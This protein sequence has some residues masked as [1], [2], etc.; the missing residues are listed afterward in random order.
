MHSP[1]LLLATAGLA[2]SRAGDYARSQR[3]RR[4][5]ANAVLQHDIKHKLD[6]ECEAIATRIL[7]DAFPES[8]ILGE[9]TSTEDGAPPPPAKGVE[10]IIDPIDGTVN[11]F[12]GLP[13]WNCSIAARVDGVV[14]AGV[15]YAPE[16]GYRFEATVDGP[17]LLNGLPIHTSATD[18]LAACTVHTGADRNEDPLKANRFFNALSE[19]CQRPR[20]MGTAA[21]DVCAVAAG[22]ADAYFEH[23][24]YIWDIAAAGLIARRAGGTG[25]IVANLGGHRLAFLATNGRPAVFDAL[26]ATLD[27]LLG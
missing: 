8:T 12:H 23:G 13:L 5:D 16:L 6:V 15:V 1:S 2:A 24:I 22:M 25:E 21:L 4:H 20:V 18:D 9:E 3:A 10:W 17:A 27:P 14:T 11:F 7:L 26:H 19:V